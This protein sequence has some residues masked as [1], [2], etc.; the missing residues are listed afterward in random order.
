M[1]GGEG[2]GIYTHRNTP[3]RS[4]SRHAAAESGSTT[5]GVPIPISI[6][7]PPARAA[8]RMERIALSVSTLIHGMRAR[9]GEE[10]RVGWAQEGREKGGGFTGGRGG[11]A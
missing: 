2:G 5:F 7:L 6:T 4:T 10:N 8:W 3:K 1:A 11:R 9:E